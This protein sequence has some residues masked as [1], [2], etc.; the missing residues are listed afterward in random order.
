MMRADGAEPRLAGVT[1]QASHRRSSP[2]REHPPEAASVGAA[3]AWI[4]LA[5]A[6]VLNVIYGIATLANSDYFHK[7][8]LLWSN[9]KAWGWVAIV[10][11]GVQLLI[12][13]KVS[14]RTLG[15]AIAGVAIACL[16]FIANFLSVGAYPIWSVIAMALN[17]W[18][19]WALPRAVDPGR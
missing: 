11:G 6:G 8:D 7:N 9:I 4:Y 16:A 15:G 10:I 19:I 17:A 5:L 1:T 2:E 13:Y 14:Q 3:F 18:V 12:A